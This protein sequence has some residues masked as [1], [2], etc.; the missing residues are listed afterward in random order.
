M[1]V[2]T[3]RSIEVFEIPQGKKLVYLW[4][5]DPKGFG[6]RVSPGGRK[7]YVVF[8]RTQERR[9]RAYSI[10]PTDAMPVDKAR[11]IAKDVLYRVA[12]GE[13]PARQRKTLSDGSRT[14]SELRDLHI[15][16][17]AAAHNKPRTV[18][19]YRWQWDSVILP[20]KLGRMT[21]REVREADVASLH[22]SKKNAPYVANGVI[23]CLSVAFNLAILEGWRD[24]NT[25]PCDNVI[26]Y[27]ERKR[28]AVVYEDQ[29][30]ALG[31]A[32]DA[33]PNPRIG[34]A[35]RLYLATGC[36][37]G[38]ILASKY[39]DVDFRERKLRIPDSKGGGPDGET[40]ELP[41]DMLTEIAKLMHADKST[42][43]IYIIPGRRKGRHM[44]NI[45]KPWRAIRKAAGLP[46]LRIH[47]LRHVFGSYVHDGGGSQ[48]E[49]ANALR[50]KRLS[51]TERYIHAN[52]RKHREV[53]MRTAERI[54]GALRGSTEPDADESIV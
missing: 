22:H 33:Y 43:N 44:V 20:S 47:D 31:M 16:G 41:D 5:D 52:D 23:R 12:N 9:Q 2:L 38:E 14:M 42:G 40:V 10:A 28:T 50:H 53:S 54:S 39:V 18:E 25:N 36:R 3:K 8:Y 51:T 30:R 26:F 49:V 48:R 34:L 29:L 27:K 32:I 17:H 6:V 7:V 11:K 46:A 13:D 4:D 15:D 19:G 35:L 45:G 1:S 37:R 24:K 21:V